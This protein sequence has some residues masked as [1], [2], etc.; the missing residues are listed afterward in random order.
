ML[1]NYKSV[2]FN[3]IL[4]VFRQKPK[5]ISANSLEKLNV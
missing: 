5:K 4:F 2:P 3:T 1:N